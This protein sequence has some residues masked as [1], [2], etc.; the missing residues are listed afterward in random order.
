MLK[1]KSQIDK[2]ITYGGNGR[3]SGITRWWM[4]DI[5]T[6][7]NHRFVE[8]FRTAKSY[9]K[10]SNNRNSETI[11]RGRTNS[12]A[13]YSPHSWDENVVNTTEFHVDFQTQI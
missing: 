6:K 11:Q 1:K 3:F 7:E 9:S 8:N 12:V 13:H 4:G 5:S 2:M 10:V